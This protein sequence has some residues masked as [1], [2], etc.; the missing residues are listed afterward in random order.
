VSGAET[1]SSGA[2]GRSRVAAALVGL[3]M[4]AGAVVLVVVAWLFGDPPV[5]TES[6]VADPGAVV[7]VTDL[8]STSY[9]A[10]LVGYR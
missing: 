7:T 5:D 9:G 10:E 8:G 1:S 6:L 3:G 4:V 2:G